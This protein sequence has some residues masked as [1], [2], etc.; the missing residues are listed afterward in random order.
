MNAYVSDKTFAITLQGVEVCNRTSIQELTPSISTTG[1]LLEDAYSRL[2]VSFHQFGHKPSREMLRALKSVLETLDHMVRGTCPD[3]IFLS[4]LDPGVGK[5]QTVISFIEALRNS[6]VEW[7][8]HVSMMVCVSRLEDIEK[9]VTTLELNTD[10][11]AILTSDEN[12][13]SQGCPDQQKARFLF[14]THKMVETRTE[15]RHFDDIREFHYMGDRR[16][17]LVWDEA[18]LPGSTLTVNR[19]DIA[20]LIK[21]LRKSNPR[22]GDEMEALFNSLGDDENGARRQLP[23]FATQFGLDA[24]DTSSVISNLTSDQ[25]RALRSLELLSGRWITVRNDG[26][27]GNTMLDFEETLPRGLAPALVLDAS[28]RVRQ[29]Y[30]LWENKRG[31]VVRLPSATKDYYDLSLHVWDTGGGKQ[32]FRRKKEKLLKG[33]S[34][35]INLR[36]GEK[37]L[38]VH[39]KAEPGLDIPA[40][41]KR[42]L[43]RPDNVSFINWGSHDATNDFAD[44]ENVILAGTLFYPASYHESLGRA[45]AGLSSE[46]G[47]FPGDWREEI[48]K[49]EHKHVIL[50]AACRGSVR[51]CIGDQ[52][53]PCNVYIIASRKSGIRP[54]LREIF[55]H[56][57]IS[58]WKPAAVQP[59]GKIAEALES[60]SE[61]LDMDPDGYVTF[62]E[63]QDA[64]GIPDRSNFRK[65]VR[66]HPLFAEGLERKGVRV[67]KVGRR[68]AFVNKR[69][70]LFELLGHSWD[71]P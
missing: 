29:T 32:S 48:E 56:C 42:L 31:G 37:W 25:E 38:V 71:A 49:G 54:L 62:K 39:H 27:S 18:M 66:E 19:V 10:E 15:G 68:R 2:Q 21:P 64:I 52:C 20:S 12:L 57:S 59:K 40:E 5:T 43:T 30:R 17:V 23:D 35:T 34:E 14:T 51:R 70:E 60:I 11:F 26:R 8:K 45:S 33:I 13:N 22:L 65:N 55:P 61:Q 47:D 36:P 7:H 67:A 46:A 50:Q 69:P 58:D 4:S 6:P 53:A 41:L 44:V 28:A 3:N 24:E 1:N 9:L 16:Q 63:V